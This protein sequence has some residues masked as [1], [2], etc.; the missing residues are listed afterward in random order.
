MEDFQMH[1][2]NAQTVLSQ[3]EMLILYLSQSMSKIL[4]PN[5]TRKSAAKKTQT[6]LI[7]S[8]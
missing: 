8:D 2:T 6:I 4:T 3:I 5:A 7:E 1:A